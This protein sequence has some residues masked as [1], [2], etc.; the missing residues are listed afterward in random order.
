MTPAGQVDSE[1]TERKLPAETTV[2]IGNLLREDRKDIK[3]GIR[4]SWLIALR[5]LF[6]VSL[7]V[8][9]QG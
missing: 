1:E 6:E 8:L 7:I 2:D 4:L 9:R 3:N 5:A